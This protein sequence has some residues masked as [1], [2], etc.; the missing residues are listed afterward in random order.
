M[1]P[2]KNTFASSLSY[3]EIPRFA[4]RATPLMM[5]PRRDLTFIDE[6]KMFF[7][8]LYIAREEKVMLLN[9][10]WGRFHPDL[11]AAV[12]ISLW[13]KQ[14]RPLIVLAGEMWE[15][16]G[17]FRGVIE[18]IVVKLADRAINR[19]AVQSS[20][21]LVVFPLNWGI[22]PN[23]TRLC[24]YYS[25]LSREQ[26]SYRSTGFDTGKYI[27]AGG[28]SHRDYKPLLEAARIM[29]EYQFV[30]ATNRLDGGVELPLNVVAGLVSHREYMDLMQS[31]AAVIVPIRQGLK[32]AAG[33]ITY[34]NS[35]WLGKLTIVNNVL[36]VRDHIQDGETGL[37]VDGSPESYV[38][39]LK[40]LLNPENKLQ[41]SQICEN[42]KRVVRDKFNVEHHI[43]QLLTIIDEMIADESLIEIKRE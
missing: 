40:W 4:D 5:P 9:S 35:M 1:T 3:P 29:P 12:V 27:F 26:E 33:H 43:E 19:Y 42:A 11:L 13:P 16:N 10:A 14:N 15:P 23:K 18:K 34:L 7:H 21:E 32:R 17:G 24:N 41:V 39:A 2:K 25:H 30:F 31:A 37:I 6:M 28:N 20:E 8:V 36:G 38:A 22:S